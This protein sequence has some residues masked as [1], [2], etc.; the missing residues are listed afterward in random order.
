MKNSSLWI[1]I[2]L[3]IFLGCLES[4]IFENSAMCFGVTPQQPPIMFTKEEST[5]SAKNPDINNCVPNIIK[6]SAIKKKGVS[7]TRGALKPELR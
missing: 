7:V 5:N 2:I 1:F 4:I 3:G 6:V